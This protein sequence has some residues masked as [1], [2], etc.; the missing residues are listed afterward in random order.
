MSSE[1]EDH[2]ELTRIEVIGLSRLLWEVGGN[3]QVDHATQIAALGYAL[4]LEQR[5][6]IPPWPTDGLGRE[7][8]VQHYRRVRQILDDRIKRL[9]ADG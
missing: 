3:E 8:V 9:E 6:A 2:I 4:Q 7:D 5:A 1:F